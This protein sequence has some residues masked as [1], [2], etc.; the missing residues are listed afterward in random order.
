[1][2]LLIIIKRKRFNQIHHKKYQVQ[3]GMNGKINGQVILEQTQVVEEDRLVET[4]SRDVVQTRSG[5]R[6]TIVPQTLRQSLGDRVISVKL[7]SIY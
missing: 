6:T 7:C 3:N 4:T 2:V 1:M 5:I